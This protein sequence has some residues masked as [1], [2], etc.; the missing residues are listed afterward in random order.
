MTTI[1][2]DDIKI[3]LLRI[4]RQITNGCDAIL[5]HAHI[6][7]IFSKNMGCNISIVQNGKAITKLEINMKLNIFLP[8]VLLGVEYFNV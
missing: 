8:A 7:K 5:N 6:L 2:K 1:V 4:L 3:M